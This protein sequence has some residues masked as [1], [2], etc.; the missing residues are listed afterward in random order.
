MFLVLF[1]LSHFLLIFTFSCLLYL[2]MTGT[3]PV[4]EVHAV[5][6]SESALE[7]RVDDKMAE[8]MLQD[9]GIVGVGCVASINGSLTAPELEI[10]IGDEDK[11]D[12]SVAMT[13]VTSYS[14]DGDLTVHNSEQKLI[15]ILNKVD[16]AH[17][18]KLL[19]CTAKV[20]GY[21]E[22]TKTILIKVRCK[23]QTGNID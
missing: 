1:S 22:K 12:D 14:S 3:V 4:E 7:K 13:K 17:S 16:P 10:A 2:H 20:K 19:Q 15:L 11:T 18:R 5:S 8:I 21:E 23:Y 6:I 9:G